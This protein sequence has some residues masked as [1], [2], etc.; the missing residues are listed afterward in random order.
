MPFSKIQ[1]NPTGLAKEKHVKGSLEDST[2]N[3]SSLYTYEQYAPETSN[4]L[5]EQIAGL[6]TKSVGV[7]GWTC[8]MCEKYFN[9]KCNA[10]SHIESNHIDGASHP[11]NICVKISSS[12][13]ALRKHLERQHGSNN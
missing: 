1:S 3:Y 12:R 8:S 5:N 6:M 4:Q 7:Q 13:D 9:K 2:E 10:R 11:C